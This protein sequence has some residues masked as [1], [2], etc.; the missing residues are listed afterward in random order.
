MSEELQVVPIEE[1]ISNELVKHNVT[2]AII[3]KLRED[4]L[5]SVLTLSNSFC[6]SISASLFCSAS[7]FFVAT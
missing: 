3:A 5:P 6:S 7:S 2:E 1:R 4:Y